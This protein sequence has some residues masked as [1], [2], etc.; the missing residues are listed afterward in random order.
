MATQM[1]ALDAG[2]VEGKDILGALLELAELAAQ[3]PAIETTN[4][5]VERLA[6]RGKP[7]L[8]QARLSF[9]PES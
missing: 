4:L 2:S 3:S 5:R 8:A 7:R 6:A 1:A 9:F